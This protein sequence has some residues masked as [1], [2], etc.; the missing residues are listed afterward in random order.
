MT[1]RH[2]SSASFRWLPIEIA[3]LVDRHFTPCR[4]ETSAQTDSEHLGLRIEFDE[5]TL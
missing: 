5:I 1:R 3:G 4:Q 2:L